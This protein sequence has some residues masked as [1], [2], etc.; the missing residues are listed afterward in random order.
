MQVVI[1]CGGMGTRI[2]DVSEAKPK[3]MLD[4]G[5]KPILWHIMK[6]YAQHGYK[7]FV[8][9]LGY[10]QDVIKDFFLNYEYL[11]NDFTIHLHSK[12]KLVHH[13]K[14]DEDWKVTLVDTGL[15][16]KKGTRIKKV[17]EFITSD[18]FMLT[19]G[20]GVS[21]VDVTKLVDFHNSHGK[22]V[23]FTG[24]QPVSRFA[25]VEMDANNNIIDWNEKKP[26]E[27]Y[28][29]AGFFVI[30]REVLE[31]IDGDVEFEEEPMKKLAQEQQVG[32]YK[33]NGFWQC[34]DTIRDYRYLNSLYEKKEA[35]WVVW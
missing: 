33:H 13:N 12:E 20:D 28:I 16:S 9:C 3:P 8:L 31:Y 22:K 27:G 32:M 4:I 35:P 14:H 15:N 30:N 17:S 23:T 5:G 6:N 7:D 1:L 26:L 18:Q 10:K 21:N 24:V 25:T 29:N 19:Y 11:N 2:R 34:M